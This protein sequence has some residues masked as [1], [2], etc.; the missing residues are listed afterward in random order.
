MDRIV[1]K[2][3]EVDAQIGVTN[4]ERARPQRLL[5]TIELER[6]LAE[7]GRTDAATATTRY[8]AVA[9]LI[10]RVVA[11]RPRNLV[12][13]VA[14]EIAKAVLSQNLALAVSVEVKKFSIPRSE[15]VSIQI[16]RTR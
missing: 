14:D 10:R 8:D 15:Y 7:A 5:I 11:E 6:D 3:L 16:R 2:N 4:P 13:S 1:I 12:E 9:D